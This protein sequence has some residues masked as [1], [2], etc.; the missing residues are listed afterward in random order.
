MSDQ[1]SAPMLPQPTG[2]SAWF[3]TWMEAVTKP[4]EQTFAV[5]AQHPDAATPN[6]AFTWVFLA[7]TLTALISGILQAILQAAGVVI[8]GMSELFGDAPRSI[9]ASLGIA[10]CLSPVS[11]ALAVLFFAI[12][13]GI[14]QWVAKLL[15]GTGT[16]SQLAY[17][18][19][20]ITVPFSLVSAVLAPFASL[21]R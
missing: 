20:A 6:R 2:V 9:A 15:G 18:T 8:P 12:L 16:F 21:I 5:M 3:S 7:G 13:V 10:I 11:G 17:T 1:P 14:F 19:A 4:N